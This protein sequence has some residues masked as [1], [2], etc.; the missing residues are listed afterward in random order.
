V[1]VGE[2]VAAAEDGEGRAEQ[3]AVG[4]D[5]GVAVARVEGDW[6]QRIALTRPCRP[7]SSWIQSPTWTEPSSCKATPPMTLPSVLCSEMVSTAATTVPPATAE[8][9]SM[10]VLAMATAVTTP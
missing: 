3:Q 7:F 1:R 8:V 9:V 5:D 4:Q 10:P 6:R 2:V